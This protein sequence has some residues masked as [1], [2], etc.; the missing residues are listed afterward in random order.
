[1]IFQLSKKLYSKKSIQRHEEQKKQSYIVDLL[2][3]PPEKKGF[4][5]KLTLINQTYLKIWLILD[6]GIENFKNT[7]KNRI[8]IKGRGAR[9]MEM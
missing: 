6:F 9:I 4:V 7:L 5:I 2:T 8:T 1:M 3:W